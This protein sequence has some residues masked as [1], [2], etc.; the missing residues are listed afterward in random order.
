[1]FFGHNAVKIEVPKEYW[2]VSHMNY[3]G[4]GATGAR[5]WHRTFAGPREGYAPP[6]HAHKSSASSSLGEVNVGGQSTRASGNKNSITG[7][8][9]AAENK[10]GDTTPTPSGATTPRAGKKKKHKNK[11]AVTAAASGGELRVEALQSSHAGRVDPTTRS[12]SPVFKSESTNVDS[13]NP[14]VD[15]KAHEDAMS[16]K[17]NV[18]VV[19]DSATTAN[20]SLSEAMEPADAENKVSTASRDDSQTKSEPAFSPEM[21]KDGG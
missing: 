8:L 11:K 1:M 9:D 16:D 5:G 21:A 12:S 4:F 14:G 2:D 17:S 3:P 6:Q 13:E 20:T 7:G 19:R 15:G 10:S 18:T